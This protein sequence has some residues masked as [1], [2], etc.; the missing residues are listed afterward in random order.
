MQQMRLA[1]LGGVAALGFALG[2]VSGLG[3]ASAQEKTF[4]LKL[5]HWV[6]PSHPL[7]KA[8]QD[9]ADDIKKEFERHHQL[10]D[11]SRPAARQG[12]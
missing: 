11:L 7:Q 9:W 2:L 1:K 6:P 12:V 10:Y 8:I 3:A 4:N 5:S